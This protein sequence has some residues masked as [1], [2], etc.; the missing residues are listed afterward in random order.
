MESQTCNNLNKKFEEEQKGAVREIML[1]K[2][3]PEDKHHFG[4]QKIESK[5]SREKART[6]HITIVFQFLQ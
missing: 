6:L 5:A 1:E 3:C 2:D 4:S